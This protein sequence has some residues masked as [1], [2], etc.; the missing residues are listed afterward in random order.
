MEA[1]ITLCAGRPQQGSTIT[2]EKSIEIQRVIP[3]DFTFFSVEN[4][5]LKQKSKAS[6]SQNISSRVQLAK[7]SLSQVDKSIL[8]LGFKRLLKPLLE[9]AH[10]LILGHSGYFQRKSL[11][12]K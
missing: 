9:V 2:T 7:N 11:R 5:P 1:G 12:I 10:L 6:E 3:D 4:Y 8:N